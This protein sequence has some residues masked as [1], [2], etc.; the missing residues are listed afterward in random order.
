MKKLYTF[1]IIYLCLF[2]ICVVNAYN[3][4]DVLILNSEWIEYNNLPEEEQLLYEVIPDQYVYKYKSKKN[5]LLDTY[6]NN[7]F[8]L[9]ENNVDTKYFNLA[10]I[11]GKRYINS[12][13]K[14]QSALG[15]CWAFGSI[16]TLESNILYNGV[17]GLDEAIKKC[18]GSNLDSIYCKYKNDKLINDYYVRNAI[19]CETSSCPKFEDETI[20][21]NKKIIRNAEFSE[22]ALDYMIS[23][24]ADSPAYNINDGRTFTLIQEKYNPYSYNRTIGGGGSFSLVAKLFDYNIA[25]TRSLK[26]WENFTIN[27]DTKTLYDVFDQDDS[28]YQVTNYFNYPAKPTNETLQ[29]EW[30]KELK[31]NI[32][33]Y[34]SVY[35]STMGPSTSAGSCYYIDD[36][37]QSLIN[38]TGNCNGSS[39]HAMQIIGWDDEYTFE[40]CKVYEPNRSSSVKGYSSY[41][42]ALN[43][44]TKEG[45]ESL[46]TRT[47]NSASPMKGIWTSG[48]GAWILKNNW[49]LAT[50]YPYLSYQSL[51]YYVYG[52]REVSVKNYDNGYNEINTNIV[53]T[54]SLNEKNVKEYVFKFDKT[55]NLE[56]L[57][58]FNV[59]LSDYNG[60]IDAY[61][62]N[63]GKNYQ[64][65]DTKY[66]DLPGLYSFDI[67]NYEVFDNEFYIKIQGLKVSSSNAFT[68]NK[69]SIDNTCD[70]N[71]E[72]QSSI[73][74]KYFTEDTTEFDIITTT[75]NVVSGSQLTYIITDSSGNDVTNLFD[76]P[77]TYVINNANKVKMIAKDILPKGKYY[78]KTIYNDH[79]NIVEFNIVDKI[80]LNLNSPYPIFA[81][82]ETVK[83]EPLLNST[84]G[85]S[86]YEWNSSNKSVATIDKNGNLTILK[87]GIT[88]ITLTIDTYYGSVTD[89]I[90]ID[91]YEQVYNVEDFLNKLANR[92]SVFYL[93]NDLDFKNI[94]F[95]DYNLATEFAGVFDGGYHTL[96]N[97]I[98]TNDSC[99]TYCGLFNRTNNATIKNF[100]IIDSEFIGK[101]S[102]G[103]VVG[104]SINT[105][106]SNVY[107]YSTVTSGITAGGII[108]ESSNSNISECYNSGSIIAI[109]ENNYSYSGGLIGYSKDNIIENSYNEGEIY[110]E[111]RWDRSTPAHSYAGG[112][113]AYSIRSKINNSYNKGK[114]TAYSPLEKNIIFSNGLIN[115]T[116]SDTSGINNSVINSYY[117]KDDYSV[118]YTEFEKTMDELKSSSTFTD[119]D[120]KNTWYIKENVITPILRN[121]PVESEKII[122][123]IFNTVLNNNS[124]YNFT[125]EVLPHTVSSDV[126]IYSEDENLFVVEDN[127]IITKNKVGT[128]NIIFKVD[129]KEYK[130]E[131]TVKPMLK[132][133]YDNSITNKDI[134]VNVNTDYY[135]DKENETYLKLIYKVGKNTKEKEFPTGS[136]ANNFKFVVNENNDIQLDLYECISDCKLINTEKFKI[137]NIDKERPIINIES[138]NTYSTLKIN[139]IDNGI[140]GLD[141]NNDYKYAIS[142][143]NILAPMVFINYTPNQ[144]INNIFI[145]HNMKYLWVKNISD[146]AGNKAS[147]ND[148]L[149]FELGVENVDADRVNLNLSSN[150]LNPN[151]EY[152]FE[153][154]ILPKNFTN[155]VNITS[156]NNE[157]FEIKN[158]KIITK[159]NTG[160]SNIIFE[161][162]TKVFK[163]PITIKDILTYEYES[164]LT[165][166]DIYV[167]IHTNY[168]K[169]AGEKPTYLK[170]IY[171][172][173][174]EEYEKRFD[175]NIFVNEYGF[176]V[177]TN[178]N[179]S[180]ELY[181]CNEDCNIIGNNNFIV[182]NIDKEK[183]V[184]NYVA[185]NINNTLQIN[186]HDFGISGLS[187]KN[188]YKYAISNS[189]VEV[190]KTFNSYIP[191]KIIN[192]VNMNKEYKYL[193]VYNIS[194]NAGNKVTEDNYLIYTIDLKTKYFNINYYNNDNTLLKSEKIK[195]DDIVIINFKP[196]DFEYENKKYTFDYWDGYKK[197]MVAKSDIN[198]YAVYKLINKELS[199]N[200]Y[201]IEN[202]IIKNIKLNN[203]NNTYDINLFKSNLIN[204]ETYNFY[205]NNN[206][207]NKDYIKTG[208]IYKNSY[209]EYKLVLTGDV[210][211]DGKVKINDVMKIANHIVNKNVLSD[212]YL[213]A[214]DVTNDNNIKM[215]DVM[216]IANA[217]VNGGNL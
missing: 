49:G 71:I 139:V 140:S 26:S 130:Y 42:A 164:K 177:T 92:N 216:K 87:S 135:T 156:E 5:N 97:I 16:G 142:D 27:H 107:N 28:I 58:R 181:L 93:M 110:S 191:N 68:K 82:D 128:N 22:R 157:L 98:K 66:V 43:T 206:L 62:S 94:N 73:G 21:E 109:S 29:K 136:M 69:C 188:N 57:T 214:G 79:E 134:E 152:S 88:Q 149:I 72:I 47:A 4:E 160:T 96:K 199:S 36:N 23:S 131:I 196:N 70:N 54:E 105:T 81:T 114:V 48:K 172:I 52:V 124:T 132:F 40:Y 217:L 197:G 200:V 185:D 171:K 3:E 158:N 18:D 162:G 108:G 44:N 35:V 150:I 41:S 122:F 125:Y 12:R 37:N 17:V 190:P 186:V 100:K 78:L 145:N 103:A 6:N 166:E 80:K 119:W 117:L 113:I 159:N 138:S 116:A 1:I 178:N 33:T 126:I 209:N 95:S 165:N 38:H 176:N 169:E 127:K 194:D 170:L 153:Y 163:F 99:L 115:I 205:E 208:L 8:S 91:I 151:N 161:I 182:S 24:P 133:V 45:C 198:L 204:Y 180:L 76:I 187:E 129:D 215:N 39:S 14:N 174:D 211:G 147:I 50:P 64:Y 31:E 83:I 203:I 34:G 104:Y 67:D 213:I 175:D 155:K 202:N 137:N 168:F 154:D 2:N 25:P 60:D 210:T 9:Y 74:A 56:Y 112:L 55:D 13:N 65:I 30:I 195:E 61:V 173:G 101:S 20:K 207:Y 90:E 84:E 32:M 51:N 189:N 19:I 192:N 89:T 11:N 167:K 102:V 141:K 146:N 46:E 15:L 143:N 120:F 75:R 201:I 212:E 53:K 106:I 85:T 77:V 7:Y 148:Y 10:N 63:D 86:N 144:V 118:N 121:F 183:P 184:L 193:W 111:T 179:I 59:I 123:N